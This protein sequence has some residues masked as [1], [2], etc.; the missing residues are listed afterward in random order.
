MR[1]DTFNKTQKKI[2]FSDK[3]QLGKSNALQISSPQMCDFNAH[4]GGF[5][6]KTLGNMAEMSRID[7]PSK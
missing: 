6:Q 3:Y 5:K 2:E 7:S 1:T 4:L